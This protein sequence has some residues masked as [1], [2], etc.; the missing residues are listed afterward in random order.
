MMDKHTRDSDTA[1]TRQSLTIQRILI[2]LD[3]SAESRL[4]LE[5]AAELAAS[6][7]AELTGLFVEDVNLLRLVDSPFV[8]EVGSFSSRPR[9][10]SGAQLERQLRAQ[11][12]QLRRALT[13]I[14]EQRRVPWSFQVARG[15]V[16]A[17]L[18]KAAAEMDM[19]ILSKT[20][21][22]PM[23]QRRTSVITRG[24]LAQAPNRTLVLQQTVRLHRPILVVYDGSAAARH[25]LATAAGFL[26]ENIGQLTVIIVADDL[27][28]ARQL[29]Q[30]AARWLQARGI[31]AYYRHLTTSQSL[32]DRL[33]Q[34]ATS[35]AAGILVL[36]NAAETALSDDDVDTVLDA[37][38]CPVL[39]VQ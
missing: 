13:R 16:A 30:E 22:S 27:E 33:A 18:A 34:L 10:L 3:A 23:G 36:P 1:E 14:A 20:S 24:F 8:R 28:A 39:V 38:R 15:L 11:A 37:V 21:W 2:A 7:G 35:D 25:A 5:T 31:A 26:R 17:E 9:A 6:W 4:A 32:P 12:S 19:I 29:R